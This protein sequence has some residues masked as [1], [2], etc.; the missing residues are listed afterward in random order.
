MNDLDKSL[1]LALNFDGGT[2]TN[3]ASWFIASAI[4]RSTADS[5]A[6]ASFS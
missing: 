3:I 5:C 6:A 4:E 2:P 1:M